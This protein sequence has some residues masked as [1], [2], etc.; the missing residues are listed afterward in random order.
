MP[1]KTLVDVLVGIRP[2]FLGAFISVAMS[3]VLFSNHLQAQAKYDINLPAQSVS[4]SLAQLSEQTDQMLLFSYDAVDGLQA[5]PV[6]GRYTLQ[7]ALNVMLAGTGFSG[8]LTKKGVLMISL[9]K[10]SVMHKE[11]KGEET[12]NKKRKLLASTIS[13]FLGAGSG[14]AV[15]AQNGGGEEIDWLLEEIVVTATKRE[16]SLQDTA[17]AISA[18]GAETI[19]KRNL[20]GL[21]DY[22]P[23][24]PGVNIQDRGAGQNS[25]V[26]RGISSNLQDGAAGAGVYYGKTP[27]ANLRN[28]TGLGS[29]SAGDLKLV[30]M[31]RVEV[32]RGPQGT[33][34]GASSLSGTVRSIPNSPNLEQIEGKLSTRLSQTGGEGGSNHMVE[35]V[36]SIPL[37][38]DVLAVRAVAYQ[39]ENSGY[40]KNVAASE[41]LSTITEGVANG[42][43]ARDRGDVGSDEY[44]GFRITTLWKPIDELNVTLMYVQQDIEQDGMPEANFDL[45]DDKQV[46]L[47]V[48]PEGLNDESAN[49]D[50]DITNLVVEYDLGWATVSSSSSWLNYEA[51]SQ[52]DFSHLTRFFAEETAVPFFSDGQNDSESFVEELNIVSRLDGPLQFTLGYYYEDKE[53]DGSA[54]WLWSGD[55]ELTPSYGPEALHSSSATTLK[56]QSFFGEVYYELTDTLELTLGVRNFDYDSAVTKNLFSR[57]G[58]PPAAGGTPKKNEKGDSYKANV[59]WRPD[60]GTLVYAQWS[61][62]FRQGAP[63]LFRDSCDARNN[64]TGEPGRDGLFDDSVGGNGRFPVPAGGRDSDLV[65]NYELGLKM[66]L[67]DKRMSV[68]AIVYQMDWT[69]IPVGFVLPSCNQ[70]VTLNAGESKAEGVEVELNGQLTQHLLLNISTSYSETT[71]EKDSSGVGLKGDNLPGSPDFQF[72]AGLEYDFDVAGN[73]AF[74]RIDYA[75]VSEYFNRTTVLPD[76]RP[77]GDFAQLHLKAGVNFD[78]VSLDVF[79][80]NL[81][82]ADD[83]TWVEELNNSASGVNRFYRLRPR[84]IGMNVSYNF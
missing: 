72:S 61:E 46:R 39:F 75:Y 18:L 19:E 2:R 81:T 35:G 57:N 26:I 55:S 64:A 32:L 47:G 76:D 38:E 62:G 48:G 68:S 82:D 52:L 73:D 43:A 53:T 15:L 58:A 78:Q 42:G 28:A 27:L 8:G 45:G 59:S 54:A 1:R 40:I 10:P 7:Q 34:Y 56:Q 84:T 66:D 12:M 9:K 13:M 60:D 25:I 3:L 11:T 41:P 4:L 67:L 36:I 21:G 65:D 24:I 44:T 16:T 37:L 80:Q 74:A 20:V 79:V 14:Q 49:A 70:F 69:G 22:L 83:V 6:L 51:R 63:A 30:D 50:I 31:A 23:T 33:L 71:L 29:S 77:A 5:A 17:M